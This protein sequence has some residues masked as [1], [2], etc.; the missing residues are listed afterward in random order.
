M[1]VDIPLVGS[2]IAILGT[3][4]NFFYFQMRYNDKIT[5]LDAKIGTVDLNEM[6]SKVDRVEM[7]M[8]LFWKALETQIPSMLLKGNPIKEESRLY[9]LLSRFRANRLSDKEVCELINELDAE[10][11]HPDHTPGET[12]MMSLFSATLKSR[13]G[14]TNESTCNS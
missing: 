2:G 3:I 8:N 7:Q 13:I 10:I 9:E 6:S 11:T 12:I 5:A 1:E 4:L 14:V